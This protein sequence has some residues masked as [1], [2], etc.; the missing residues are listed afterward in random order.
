MNESFANIKLVQDFFGFRV[1]SS[2]A[3]LLGNTAVR[4]ADSWQSL[5]IFFPPSQVDSTLW[6]HS[7]WLWASSNLVKLLFKNLLIKSV[8]KECV[9]TWS[10]KR[11]SNMF[12][13]LLFDFGLRNFCC[14]ILKNNLSRFMHFFFFLWREYSPT[15]SF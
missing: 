7:S 13:N 14:Y 9:L 8:V 1:V 15:S 12:L 3:S 5:K 10:C 2:W 6:D 11:F 4:F